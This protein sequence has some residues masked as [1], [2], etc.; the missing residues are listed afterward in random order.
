MSQSEILMMKGQNSR[1]EPLCGA[2]RV[3]INAITKDV[4]K[5]QLL[6]KV[7]FIMCT[8]YKNDHY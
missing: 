1:C 3:F 6:N 5:L 2:F 7:H 8:N 4:L